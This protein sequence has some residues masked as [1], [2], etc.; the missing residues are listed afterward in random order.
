MTALAMEAPYKELEVVIDN[1]YIHITQNLTHIMKKH[2][3]SPLQEGLLNHLLT[4]Y[5]TS[6]NIHCTT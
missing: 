2:K 6:Q 1:Q 3:N 4:E 5:S